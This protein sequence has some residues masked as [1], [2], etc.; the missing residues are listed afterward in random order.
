MRAV[1][2]GPGVAV[3]AYGG[4]LLVGRTDTGQLVEAAI[5]L[6]SGVLLHTVVPSPRTGAP[7][8]SRS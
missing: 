3:T 6:A 7:L 1:L 8:R 4:W 2:G 5:W